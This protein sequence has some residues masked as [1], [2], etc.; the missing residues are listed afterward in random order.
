MTSVWKERLAPIE[1]CWSQRVD[2]GS[3][4][5]K[6]VKDVLIFQVFDGVESRLDIFQN[7]VTKWIY[8]GRLI[9]KLVS[10]E[11][12]SSRLLIDANLLIMRPIKIR[13]VFVTIFWNMSILFQAWIHTTKNARNS[14][15]FCRVGPEFDR[16]NV[17]TMINID[18][19]VLRSAAFA[20]NQSPFHGQIKILS[21]SEPVISWQSPFHGVLSAVFSEVFKLIKQFFYI[22]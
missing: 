22:F 20:Q 9:K 18:G 10:I 19:L 14:T 12:W 15:H 4:T 16:F 1:S 21:R 11:S 13:L 3:D 6:N 7:I 17:I 5:T 2:V 8:I